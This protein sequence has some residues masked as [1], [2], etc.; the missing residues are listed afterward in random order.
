M[1][2]TTVREQDDE[3]EA[4]AE[5]ENDYVQMETQ[6]KKS[7]GV[8]KLSGVRMSMPLPRKQL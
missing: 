1:D 4:E 7:R 6:P 2:P 5:A 3:A 8:P